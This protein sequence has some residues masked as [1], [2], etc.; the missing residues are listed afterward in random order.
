[1]EAFGTTSP[2]HLGILSSTILRSPLIKWILPARIR[3][4]SK[5]DVVFI[6]ENFVHVKNFCSDGRLEHVASKS[7]FGSRILSAKVIGEPLEATD[8]VCVKHEELDLLSSPTQ[9]EDSRVP[10]QMVVLATGSHELLFVYLQSTGNDEL[11]FAVVVRPLPTYLSHMEMPGQGMAVDPKSRAMAVT[12]FERNIVIYSL[13]SATD[14]RRGADSRFDNIQPIK[15]ECHLNIQGC[16]LHMDFLHPEQGDENHV[17]LLL[18]VARNNS[19]YIYCCD[20]DLSL[21]L[22]SLQMQINGY[23]MED[24]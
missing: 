4:P 22:S 23:R 19:G 13:N 15:D 2:P 10:F 24:S 9:A 6:G 11:E 7:D 20:W 1:M 5:N 12:A 18:I 16:I 3:H 17:T 14:P 21:P 8:D